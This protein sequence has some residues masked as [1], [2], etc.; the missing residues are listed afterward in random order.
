ML[1]PSTSY[2][3]PRRANP[4]GKR[5]T[6][7]ALTFLVLAAGC[8]AGDSGGAERNGVGATGA[9]SSSSAPHGSPKSTSSS[10]LGAGAAGAGS[11]P[12]GAGPLTCHARGSGSSE[13][14]DPSCTPG[15]VNSAVTQ[16][17]IDQSICSAGWTATVRPP[18]S[19]T[20][21]LK[22][23]QMAAYGD[24]GPVSSY[25]EDHLIPIGLGGSPT[26]PQNLWPEPGASPNPKDAV[27]NAANHAVCDGDMNLSAAQ[28]AI[29]A[30][31]L[32]FGHQLGVVQSQPPPAQGSTGQAPTCTVAASYNARYGDWDVYVHSNQ[33]D[34]TVTVTTSGGGTASW[35]TDST[36]YAD[37][38]LHAA[39][40]S[41]GQQVT[42][43]VGAASC[44]TPL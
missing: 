39:R 17:N 40:S 41:F 37:V 24:T 29:A 10:A 26:S 4:T 7:G 27:E 32:A 25:E 44:S 20:E 21:P 6:V 30:N 23:E 18:E 16:A 5:A 15:A 42:A 28:H 34:Q 3:E 12:A 19:Y 14:P 43:R 13:L 8:H 9:S 31:W 35:H 1:R 36:G 2:V 38:Y 33:L 22:Y 11:E